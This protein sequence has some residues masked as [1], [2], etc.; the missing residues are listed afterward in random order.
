MNKLRRSACLLIILLLACLMLTACQ[1]KDNF[2]TGKK[3]SKAYVNPETINEVAP[4]DIKAQG[5]EYDYDN[6]TYDLV[7]SDEFDYEGFP[8]ESKW[9]YDV[10][11]SGWG[12]NELQY[13]TKG[14]N[15]AVKDG[16]L[17]IE[18]RKEEYEGM[19]YTS[20]RLITKGKG[21]WLYGKVEVKAKLPSGLGTWPAIWMLPTDWEYG[22]WPASGEIDIMEHVGY[23]QD[24]VH[25]TV[26]TQSY[27]HGIGTQKGASKRVEGVSDDFHV[28]SIE[29]LPDKIMG[30]VDGELYYTFDPN[31]YK[32]TPTFKEWPFDKRFHLLLNIAFGGNW[33]GAQGID[34]NIFPTQMVVDYVRVYQSKEI[35]E[36]IESMD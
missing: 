14:E 12:N 35:N 18:A 28:Y 8:D 27:Y 9:G 13:Y 20:S 1:E 26:H 29:W 3:L 24:V 25:A 11:G 5:F 31:Q 10:G 7:W 21:D 16:Y 6:L 22:G 34:E 19:N 2:R 32:S 4:E 15:V 36:L 17:T 33:G 30:Y 23:D